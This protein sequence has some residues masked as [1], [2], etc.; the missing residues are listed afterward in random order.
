MLFLQEW[1]ARVNTAVELKI[2]P[3]ITGCIEVTD[4]DEVVGVVNDPVLLA[5]VAVTN[6]HCGELSK[7]WSQLVVDKLAE[8]AMYADQAAAE[9]E[10]DITFYELE[11]ALGGFDAPG[12]GLRRRGNELVLVKVHPPEPEDPIEALIRKLGG[13]DGDCV[14]PNCP[15]HG[16]LGS[17]LD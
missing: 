13:A 9:L 10:R 5:L 15:G 1:L 14:D 7:K 3:D 16:H 4:E 11:R 6:T 8:Q 17:D 2:T 12:V